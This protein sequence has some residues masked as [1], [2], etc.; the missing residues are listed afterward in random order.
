ME[1]KE[2][3]QLFKNH[4]HLSKYIDNIQKKMNM[5]VFYSI[6]PIDVKDEEYPNLIYAAQGSV[7]IHIFK[8]R[9]MDEV[10]YHA[11]EPE[12]GDN[13]RI[14]HDQLLKI[15]VKKAPEKKS[16]IMLIS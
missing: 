1:Q 12:L 8:T 11:V 13:E 15:I 2:I 7:F 9:D 14:K 6:L 16:V 3:D 5:P 10:E 4:P